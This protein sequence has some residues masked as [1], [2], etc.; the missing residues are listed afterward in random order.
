MLDSAWHFPRVWL[1]WIT[2]RTRKSNQCGFCNSA[3]IFMIRYAC[4]SWTVG[5]L[6]QNPQKSSYHCF[7][8]FF[9]PDIP[10]FLFLHLPRIFDQL[11]WLPVFLFCNNQSEDDPNLSWFQNELKNSRWGLFFDNLLFGLIEPEEGGIEGRCVIWIVRL[12][13]LASVLWATLH[14]YKNHQKKGSCQACC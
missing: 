8:R 9:L 4:D 2:I 14:S 7:Y 11:C 1:V 3:S 13:E 6:W 5:L 12:T 10:H